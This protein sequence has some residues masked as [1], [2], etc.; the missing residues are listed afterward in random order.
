MKNTFFAE[1]SRQSDVI[2]LFRTRIIPCA[3]LLF[4]GCLALIVCALC[5]PASAEAAL[6][7]P[8]P[9][10]TQYGQPQT[11]NLS[12]TEFT[13]STP[14]PSIS[15][16]G[17][18]DWLV[19]V[20]PSTKAKSAQ[21]RFE[22]KRESGALV[23]RRTRYLNDLNKK[24]DA[25]SATTKKAP[26][27]FEEEFKRDLVGL[28]LYEGTYT[29]ATEV[30]VSNGTERETA[31][32][33]SYQYIYDASAD[34]LKWACALHFTSVPLRN[35]EGL[36]VV[37]PSQG[38]PEVQR[39]ALSKIAALATARRNSQITLYISPLLLDDFEA[40]SKGYS[41]KLPQDAQAQTV[42]V[43]SA[44]PQRYAETLTALSN[45][46]A[47][48][49]LSLGT[50][51]YADP[52]ITHL[53]QANRTDDIELQ[54]AR[55]L[56]TLSPLLQKNAQSLDASHTAPLGT[57]INQTTIDALKDAKISGVVIDDTAVKNAAYA[58]GALDK[59]L[60]GYVSDSSLSS[61]ITSREATTVSD[62][63]FKL[64]KDATEKDSGLV[65]THSV[66][67]NE[68]QALKVVDNVDMLYAQPWISP[69]SFASITPKNLD[70]APALKLKKMPEGTQ[71]SDDK[72]IYK[73]R[74]ASEG[75]VFALNEDLISI[76]ARE[77]SLIAENGA[78]AP[79]NNKVFFKNLK[80]SFAERAQRV[81]DGIFKKVTVKVAPVTLSGREGKVPITLKNGNKYE[82]RVLLHF[83]TSNGMTLDTKK[84][85]LLGLPPQETF[86][87]PTVS[88]QN[89]SSG[90]L[91]LILTAGDYR[92]GEK[93]VDISA[94]YIDT[95]AIVV[96]VVVIGIALL[97][98][99]Y[100]R[101][102][103]ADTS[104]NL[105]TGEEDEPCTGTQID[106]KDSADTD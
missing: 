80:L 91:K 59:T 66:V 41:I 60:V 6:P 103:S 44:V 56:S 99:I 2:R 72:T 55:A 77:D 53:T 8:S 39:Q 28:G 12:G 65:V 71:T 26:V 97:V 16:E 4:W 67:S 105:F 73:A 43:N 32:L 90:E 51:G 47:S 33:Y 25:K 64:R 45:A 17:Q 52:D 48:G 46:F 57:K 61:L 75:L 94:S 102:S 30:T 19:N 106:R 62:A 68:E 7:T 21:I 58:V 20:K 18:L 3:V 92:L 29:I 13:L 15:Q 101:V 37:D 79:Q 104:V 50:L 31:S 95:I 81:V 74:K 27:S 9:V 76:K 100:K 49:A 14:T 34:P 35:P 88:M 78:A 86:L 89:A 93:N 84:T 63:F 42:D 11:L 83:A 24:D 98:F 70:K 10:K 96:I 85:T 5:T 87:E 36:F 1:T 69:A 38:A 82:V 22:V 23:Y 54:Y 40:I